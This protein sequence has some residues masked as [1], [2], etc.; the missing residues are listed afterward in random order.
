M[1]NSTSGSRTKISENTY[2]LGTSTCPY[3]PLYRT[4]GGYLLRSYIIFRDIFHNMLRNARCGTE[5]HL[6]RALVSGP[7]RFSEWLDACS[8][9]REYSPSCAIRVGRPLVTTQSALVH[10]ILV[11]QMV[12]VPARTSL[13]LKVANGSKFRTMQIWCILY[14]KPNIDCGYTHWIRR[15]LRKGG[16]GHKSFSFCEQTLHKGL[17]DASCD[18][19]QSTRKNRGL[20]I[21]RESYK[22]KS[23]FRGL[24]FHRYATFPHTAHIQF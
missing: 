6:I 8:N 4:C 20:N 17:I 15:K 18:W 1:Y 22:L 14:I 11:P 16:Q 13:F 23:N 21:F 19:L 5:S 7:M 24:Y 9:P 2:S 10:V 3:V 12:M